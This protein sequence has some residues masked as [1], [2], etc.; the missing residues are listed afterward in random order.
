MIAAS[1]CMERTFEV[2]QAAAGP[3]VTP[4][5]PIFRVLSAA[6]AAVVVTMDMRTAATGAASARKLIS[7]SLSAVRRRGFGGASIN[8]GGDERWQSAPGLSTWL[9]WIVDKTERLM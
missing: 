4:T 3:L 9:F 6:P 1:V 5:K 8:H 2:P 7:S